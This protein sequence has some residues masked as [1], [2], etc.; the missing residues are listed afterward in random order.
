MN[1][2]LISAVRYSDDSYM[3]NL[4]TDQLGFLS[5]SVKVSRRT[6]VRSSYLTPLTQLQIEFSG[7]PSQSVMRITECQLRSGE[8]ANQQ[9][10]EVKLM[11]SQVVAELLMKVL[12]RGVQDAD[13]FHFIDNSIVSFNTMRRG[14]ENFHL[15]F[16]LKLTHYLGLFHNIEGATNGRFFNLY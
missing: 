11:I 9:N 15:I 7:R 13:L 1:A 2:I 10:S 5:A 6:V 4:F 3:L 12:P 14:V 8:V 16:L